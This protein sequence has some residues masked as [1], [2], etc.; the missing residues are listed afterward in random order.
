M[1]IAL[2]ALTI[3]AS[4][5]KS[6]NPDANLHI[7]GTVKGLK[8]GKL[9]VQR[10]KDTSFVPIDTIVING[11]SNFESHLKIDSPEM[12][13][14][15]LDR[16]Q[17]NSIDNNLPFFAEPGNMKIETSNEQ[18]FANARISGSENQVAYDNFK[19]IRAR[20]TDQKM[21]LVQ[22]SIEAMKDGN[23]Q[24]LDSINQ[25]LDMLLKRRYLYTVNFALANAKHEV[26][27]YIALSEIYDANVK[28]LDTIAKSMT[29]EVSKSMYGK[30]LKKFI[31]E[32]KKAM[33]APV[34]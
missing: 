21:E 31:A 5:N 28:Y 23:A 6:D 13:Y 12:L 29:P 2:A 16:G 8:Q 34:K 14:L 18:F 33:Q 22:K 17:T 1:L 27:P 20:F 25:K 32:R 4:C 9:Y 19:K 24:R 30:E 7:T 11:N 15:F 3:A 26:A 10:L